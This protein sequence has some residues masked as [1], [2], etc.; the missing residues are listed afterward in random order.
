VTWR[1]GIGI[2]L[3]RVAKVRAIEGPPFLQTDYRV[4]LFVH[5][6]LRDG[7]RIG[8]IDPHQPPSRSLSASLRE[9]GRS[10]NKRCGIRY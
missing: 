6:A 4:F 7:N 10:D 5:R 2:F 1:S 3:V 9:A 8:P